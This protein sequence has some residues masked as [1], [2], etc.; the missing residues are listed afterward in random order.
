MYIEGDNHKMRNACTMF[1]ALKLG[2]T[3]KLY[4]ILHENCSFRSEN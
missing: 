4:C 1:L 3:R 2:F